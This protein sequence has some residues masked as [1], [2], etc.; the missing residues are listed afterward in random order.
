MDHVIFASYGNDSVALIQWAYEQGLKDVHVAYSDTGWAACYW[1]SRVDIAEHWVRDLGFTP[2]RIKSEGMEALVK[3]K[4]AWPRGGGHR[5]QW[6]TAALK[7]EPA[8]KWLDAHD[9]D[10]EA[11][12]MVGIRR[13]EGAARS[14]APEWVEES[15][16]HGGRNL[17]SP[18]V[19]HTEQMRDDLIRKTPL[20]VLPHRSKECWP[21]VNARHEELKHLDPERID[22]IEALE[23]DA[24]TN[25]KGNPRVMYRPS[26]H[27]G[28]VGIRAVVEH[29]KGSHDDLFPVSVC[30]SGWC[31]R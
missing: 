5:F 12:C 9:P 8:S 1:A 27:G 11:I 30:D 2:H 25:S 7:I 15:D 24:G 3:R 31:G 21:C 26:R 29:A 28:A 14:D 17:W 4:K 22:Y 23:Q 20:P 19:R 16:N 18:L 6:C 13:E 10:G